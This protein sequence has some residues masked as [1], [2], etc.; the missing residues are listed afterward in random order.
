MIANV[1][2]L[3]PVQ[4]SKL[5]FHRFDPEFYNN[6]QCDSQWFMIWLTI[7]DRFHQLRFITNLSGG[8]HTRKLTTS[9]IHDAWSPISFDWEKKKYFRNGINIENKINIKIRRVGRRKR[10]KLDARSLPF[11]KLLIVK[12]RVVFWFF[13]VFFSLFPSISNFK[14]HIAQ[15]LSMEAFVSHQIR[16]DRNGRQ[17]NNQCL[18]WLWLNNYRHRVITIDCEEEW[19]AL[20]AFGELNRCR[21]FWSVWWG[22]LCAWIQNAKSESMIS[23]ICGDGRCKMQAEK[24]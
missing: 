4:K 5:R 24:P 18:L 11:Q 3:P 1:C 23:M 9:H 17:N 12:S 14:V 13:F 20:L 6:S 10:M 19:I 7:G 15:I 2:C 22:L 16:D 8:T 21:S